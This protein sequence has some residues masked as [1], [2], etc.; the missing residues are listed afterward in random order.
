MAQVRKNG[1]RVPPQRTLYIYLQFR[2]AD[3]TD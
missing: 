3:K 2:D 1:K